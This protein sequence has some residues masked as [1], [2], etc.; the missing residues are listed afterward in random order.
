M[1]AAC[2]DF[3]GGDNL[4]PDGELVSQH[5]TD[6]IAD[7]CLSESTHLEDYGGMLTQGSRLSYAFK[8]VATTVLC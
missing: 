8:P 5:T 2:H 7:I 4:Q 3:A 6:Y 1:R